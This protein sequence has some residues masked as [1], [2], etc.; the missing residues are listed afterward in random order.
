MTPFQEVV[1]LKVERYK[2][3][4]VR[5]DKIDI[6]VKAIEPF[7][8]HDEAVFIVRKYELNVRNN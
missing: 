3:T 2:A 7:L 8:S 4:P 1:R 5:Q 6:R